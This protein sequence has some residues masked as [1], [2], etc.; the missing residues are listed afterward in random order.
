MQPYMADSL[1]LL[2][3]ISSDNVQVS[4]VVDALM[5]PMVKILLQDN[6]IHYLKFSLRPLVLEMKDELLLR[7]P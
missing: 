1:E 2:N 4:D 6:G 3:A 5:K 7:K